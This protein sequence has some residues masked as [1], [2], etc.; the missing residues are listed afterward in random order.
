MK[1]AV[2]SRINELIID[3]YIYLDKAKEIKNYL[4]QKLIKGEYD[5]ITTASDFAGT[6]EYDLRD[7]SNDSHFRVEFNPVEATRI[8]ASNDLDEEAA[9]NARKALYEELRQQNFG[10][11]KVERLGGNIGSLDLRRFASV[12]LDIGNIVL[13]KWGR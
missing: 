8:L 9:E 10:L 4:N 12:D 6:L 13:C 7:I 1:T 11:F 3:K 2:I 5:K